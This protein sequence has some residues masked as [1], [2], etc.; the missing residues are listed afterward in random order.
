MKT[1][2]ITIIAMKLISIIDLSKLSHGTSGFQRFDP[3]KTYASELAA[4][5]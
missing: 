1:V 5:A 2:T 4:E 3:L